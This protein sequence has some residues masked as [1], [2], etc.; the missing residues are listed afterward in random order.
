MGLNLSTSTIKYLTGGELT[1]QD[2]EEF[3][4]D[5]H[6]HLKWL[7]DYDVTDLGIYFEYYIKIELQ[8]ELQIRTI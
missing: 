3:D 7:L 1:L 5:I 2:M 6:H 4:I 8:I